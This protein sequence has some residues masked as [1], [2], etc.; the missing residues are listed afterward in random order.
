MVQK[1]QKRIFYLGAFAIGYVAFE[2]IRSAQSGGLGAIALIV[3]PLL[4]AQ[5]WSRTRPPSRG[6]DPIEPSVR[7]AARASFWGAGMLLAARTS[8]IDDGTLEAAANLGTGVAASASLVALA[9][10]HHLGGA[11]PIPKAARRLDLASLVALP[12]AG[13]ILLALSA[14][15]TPDLGFDAR[16]ARQSSFFAGMLSFGILFVAAARVHLLRRLELGVSDRSRAAL[17]S[18]ALAWIVAS[19]V[20]LLDLSPPGWA[21]QAATVASSVVI[22]LSCM[23]RDSVA[24]ARLYRILFV[25]SLAA[26]PLIVFAATIALRA[27]DLAGWAVLGTALSG[28]VIGLLAPFAI[29]PLERERARWLKTI[30]RA[31]AQALDPD[32]ERAIESALLTLRDAAGQ[33]ENAPTLFH[34]SLGVVLQTD[35]AG[36]LH[37]R[38]GEIPR[39]VLDAALEEPE[40]TLRVEALQEIEVRRADLRP[41]LS[42]MRE[43]EAFTATSLL[44]DGDPVGAL[45]LPRGRRTVSLTLEEARALSLLA[46]RLAAALEALA[47]LARSRERELR[48]RA[49]ADAEDDRAAR[50]QY[51][52]D[53]K[54]AR[55]EAE[56]R[57]LARKASIASYSPRS[58]LLLDELARLGSLG[59]PLSLIAPLGVDPIP[60]AAFVHL[61]GHAKSQAF[62][63]VDCADPEEQSLASW[64]CPISSPL[65]LTGAGTLVALSVEALP[66]ETQGFLALSLATRRSPSE[67]ATPL[68]LRL[69]ATSTRSVEDLFASGRLIPELAR[70]LG[71]SLTLPSLAERSEDLHAL[72]LDYL[73]R[74]GIRLRGEPLGIDAKAMARLVDHAFPGNEHELEDIL[75]RAAAVAE[76][77]LVRAEDLQKIG[78]VPIEPSE[79]DPPALALASAWQGGFSE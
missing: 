72:A 79:G 18:L 37:R 9:R 51:L 69:I 14:A 41:A 23:A 5:A 43:E 21:L 45:V 60:F 59:T 27:P 3:L 15:L 1:R 56:A 22:T 16:L 74:I 7:S 19:V 54:E 57:R 73:G 75:S 47:R 11:L 76:G 25:V 40:R 20:G 42:W 38:E 71:R 50:L 34:S 30:E 70:R 48:E 63:V 24:L 6:E 10:I 62:I 46:D 61:H 68:D 12:W 64:Q 4:L 67:S 44:L 13:A 31:S 26:A 53:T 8:F 33:A 29:E 78:F 39:L 35:H 66:H 2:S 55:Y 28:I 77:H 49:R 17:Y 52:L 36:Y 58:R 65:A 32:P